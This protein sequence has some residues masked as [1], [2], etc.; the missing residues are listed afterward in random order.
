VSARLLLLL[1]ATLCWTLLSRIH[2]LPRSRHAKSLPPAPI[3]R[4]SFSAE[5]K[6]LLRQTACQRRSQSQSRSLLNQRKILPRQAAVVGRAVGKGN[7][8][9]RHRGKGEDLGTSLEML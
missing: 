9:A 2:R 3:R 1:L 7:R 8:E 5:L 4:R 6:I